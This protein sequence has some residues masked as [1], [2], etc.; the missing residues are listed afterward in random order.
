MRNDPLV[1][2]DLE[3]VAPEDYFG[4][5]Y[6]QAIAGNI[7]LCDPARETDSPQAV[8]LVARAGYGSGL[9]MKLAD[10]DAGNGDWIQMVV[11]GAPHASPKLDV[12]GI[13]A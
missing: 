1:V 8:V 4:S 13:E 12:S 6:T 10:S 7:Y 3:T 2:A 11:V 9:M 5:E